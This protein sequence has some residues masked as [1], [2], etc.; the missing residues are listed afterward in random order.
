MSFRNRSEIA[1]PHGLITLSIPLVNGRDQKTVLK[2]VRIRD[3]HPWRAQHWKTLQSCYN[4]SPWFD[5]FREGLEGLYKRPAQFLLDWNLSCFEWSL[6]VLGRPLAWSLTDEYKKDYDPKEWIDW[7]G[8]VLPKNRS[9][10]VPAEA[11]TEGPGNA[12]MGMPADPIKYRQVFEE[13]TGFIPNLSIL[14]LLFC[15]GK[16]AA[17]VLCPA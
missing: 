13:R 2:E 6:N 16:R 17:T 15:E 4:R 10:G 12:I 1:G 3:E 14:D 9:T 8:R 11:K 5:F 7:R